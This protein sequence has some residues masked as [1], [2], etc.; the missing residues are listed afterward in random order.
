MKWVY[1]RTFRVC[2][3]GSASD[4]ELWTQNAIKSFHDFDT[5]SGINTLTLNFSHEFFFLRT[6]L[7]V[8]EQSNKVKLV[9]A[10]RPCHHHNA[11]RGCLREKSRCLSNALMN[12][13]NVTKSWEFK[14]RQLQL[15]IEG[16]PPLIAYC[17]IF[18]LFPFSLKKK[19]NT[20]GAWI[21][22]IALAT[23]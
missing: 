4:I 2:P 13:D 11:L 23:L 6:F 10:L 14:V 7:I 15:I 1:I 9:D 20:V 3:Q 18:A 22:T 19:K 12:A 16:D 8:S 21:G 5:R 17:I